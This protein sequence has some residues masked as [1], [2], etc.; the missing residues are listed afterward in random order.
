MK[1]EQVPLLRRSATFVLPRWKLVYVSTPKAACT[2]IKWLLSDLQG[3]EPQMFYASLSS[4]TTRATTVHQRR[5]LWRGTPRLTDLAPEDLEAV[6]PENGWFF[7][8]MTRHPA[9]RLWSGWQSKFL[10]REP[11]F[12]HEFRDETWL[13]RLPESTDDVMDDWESFIRAISKDHDA[14]VLA[15][16]HFRKQSELLN[17]GVAPYD[18]VYDTSEFGQM[19]RDLQTH[20]EA[21]GYTERLATRRSNETPLPPIE[22]AFPSHVIDTIADIYADDYA[23]LG[24]TDARPPRL[25]TGDYSKE[26]VGATSIIAERGERIG[27]L[28]WR[29]RRLDKSLRECREQ[30][31]EAEASAAAKRGL[32]QGLT[33]SVRRR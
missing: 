32:W 29:A 21:Q 28:A 9:T 15:D 2:T 31:R 24:Y 14:P 25:G 10:L 13:P 4:E 7:F 27:D 11:R 18:R 26:L 8:T 19:M 16:I 5:V 33:K 20:V 23:K 12:M 6:T 22:R 30:S 17:I 3:Y 1:P